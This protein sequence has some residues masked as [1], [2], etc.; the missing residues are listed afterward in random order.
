MPLSHRHCHGFELK[1][2]VDFF[3]SAGG[4][5][6]SL[7]PSSGGETMLPPWPP[8]ERLVEEN[9]WGEDDD[10]EEYIPLS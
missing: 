4:L 8:N 6:I 2:L 9:K 3:I 7:S 5:H 10:V 1:L